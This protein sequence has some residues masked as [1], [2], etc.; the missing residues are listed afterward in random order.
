MQIK[1]KKHIMMAVIAIVPAVLFG[2]FFAAETFVTSESPVQSADAT[3]QHFT[4]ELE[5][6]IGISDA[7]EM[8]ENGTSDFTI[9]LNESISI[10]DSVEVETP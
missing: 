10:S 5:E 3:P 1:N 7:I 6:S 9:E 2:G 8:N 4:I